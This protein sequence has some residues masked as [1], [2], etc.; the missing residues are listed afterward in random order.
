MNE[1]KERLAALGMTPEQ[2][3]GALQE[4]AGF[5]KAKL[6][7]DYTWIVDSLMAGQTPDVSHLAGELF[8]KV[9]GMFD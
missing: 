6:P 2:I 8:G 9:K 4:V 1:L 5:V 3:D 7:A